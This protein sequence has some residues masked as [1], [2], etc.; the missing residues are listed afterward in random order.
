MAFNLERFESFAYSRNREMGMR[1]LFALLQDLDNNYGHLGA[2]F[3][4]QPL[5]AVHQEEIDQHVWTRTAAAAS[6]LLADSELF[7]APEWQLRMMTYHRWLQTL[8]AASPF[9]NADHVMRAINQ[10]EGKDDLS[11]LKIQ[12]KDL[13]KFCLLF[14]PESE[15]P[16]DLDALW[17]QDKYLAASLCLVLLSPRFLGSPAAHGKR[18]QI[19]PWLANRLDQVDD[20]EKLPIGVLHDLYMHCSYAD[21]SDKHDIKKPIN[22]L[23]RRKLRD[24]G[25]KDRAL[26]E[27]AGAVFNGT[28]KPVMM[29]VHEWF[30]SSHSMYRTH[31]RTIEAARDL[32][33]VIGMGYEQCLD[34]TTRKV[35][36][37]VISIDN[38]I[39]IIEQMKHI[40]REARRNKVAVLYMPS[41]G[42]FP[43]TMWQ[44]NL[45]VAPLQLM[46]TGHPATSHA[47]AMDY[48]VVEEDFV[49]D[50]K[51]FS[52]KMIKL[53][54]DGMPYRPSAS[55]TAVKPARPPLKKP[56]KVEI[57]VCATTMK[58]NPQFLSACARI[59]DGCKIPVHFHFLVGQAQGLIYPN[60]KRV[61]RMFLSD[62][63]TVYPHQEYKSYMQTIANCDL[64][65][66]PFPFGNTNGIIDCIT[67][68]LVGICKTG[69]EVHEHI[70]EALFGRLGMPD[71]MVA[72]TIDDYVE[73]AVRLITSHE[74]RYS[75]RQLM[76]G[77]SKV[78]LFF[79]G[80]PE[81]MGRLI[82]ERL[83]ETVS[84]AKQP[85]LA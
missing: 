17:E 53:P 57:A 20:I 72:K 25:L 22:T 49:G 65:I 51:C 26:H 19:L 18:E 36:D 11:N 64:F 85:A 45:R 44:A 55:S 7:I 29:V 1:E 76:S 40:Q 31:S 10:G 82:M 34:D 3:R 84:N 28:E 71:W 24:L 54:T 4:A 50:E 62:Y 48:L 41:V 70:D 83:K 81:L 58:L 35:F 6:A 13:L 61:V 15:V 73:A 67:A 60:V 21:R 12:H 42:M 14:T 74:E 52:E 69:P 33:H 46:G 9:Q 23:V 32:F 2:N 37:E 79:K 77:P 39:P 43:L 5:R 59:V 16:L 63:A 27:T 56:D 80:R 78:E 68:G 8:F 75:L 66:N 38:T 30:T 47:H